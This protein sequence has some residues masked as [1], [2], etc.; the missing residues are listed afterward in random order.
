MPT[1]DYV[2]AACGHRF[3]VFERMNARGK[4]GCPECGRPLAKRSF[5]IGAG[6]I[7]KGKGFYSTEYRNGSSS[8]AT[9]KPAAPETPKTAGPEPKKGS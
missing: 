1:Y 5:G 8:K 3:E 4:R 9:E 7:F 6:L 2:C